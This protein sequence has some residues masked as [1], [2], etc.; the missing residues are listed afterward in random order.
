MV[1]LTRWLLTLLLPAI[2][3]LLLAAGP[4]GAMRCGNELVSLGDRTVEVLEKCGPPLTVDRWEL[5]RQTRP[6]F[7]FGVWEQVLIEEW[8][9]NLGPHKFMRVLRFENGRL[10]D[11]KTVGK[12][13]D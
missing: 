9:Y 7:R 10:V 5:V 13:F 11:E 2:V 4:A 8:L 12:G 3:V 1:H 6:F